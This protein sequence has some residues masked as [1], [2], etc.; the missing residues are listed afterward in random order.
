MS[1]N[2]KNKDIASETFERSLSE[3]KEAL[4]EYLNLVRIHRVRYSIGKI[5][6][7]ENQPDKS[8]AS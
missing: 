3:M 1:D 4:A 5:G 6:S 2:I 8:N 7:F